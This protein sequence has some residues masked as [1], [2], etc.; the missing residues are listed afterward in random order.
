LSLLIFASSSTASFVA[1]ST[2]NARHLS[3]LVEL[4][5]RQLI[6]LFVSLGASKLSKK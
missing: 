5:F 4:P 3:S 2:F 6:V 1:A